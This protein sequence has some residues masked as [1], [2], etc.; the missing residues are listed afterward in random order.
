M[1]MLSKF[2]RNVRKMSHLA[3]HASVSV[4]Y[5]KTNSTSH[6]SP[7]S[8]FAE[9]CDNSVD[10]KARHLDI[11]HDKVQNKTV[12]T[13]YDDGQGMS[14]DRL[15]KCLSLGFTDKT[16][17]RRQIGQYGNGFKSSYRRLGRN[18]LILTREATTKKK[19][20]FLQ[21]FSFLYFS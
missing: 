14:M 10:A 2:F 7:L 17:N 19:C 9:L 6:T 21:K 13:I 16:G 15:K 12:L 4:S 3:E 1:L 11:G 8:A 18:V 5:L 20:K